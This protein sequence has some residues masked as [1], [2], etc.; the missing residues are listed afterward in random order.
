MIEKIEEMNPEDSSVS[1]PKRFGVIVADPPWSFNDKLKYSGTVKR[2]ADSH[3]PTLNLTEIKHLPI[4]EIAD[5]N[6]LLA[7]WVPS[8]FLVAGL[9]IMQAW[10]F[11]YKQLWVW[12]KTSKKNPLHLAFGMGRLA[13][14]CH[15]P[16][17]IGV[18]G[19]YTKSL[20]DHSQRNLFMH[21][22]TK[23]SQKPESIQAS[24]EKMFPDWQKLEI[25]ARRDRTGWTCIGN[26]APGTFGED[27]RDSIGNLL[28]YS[29]RGTRIKTG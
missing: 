19:N 10:G 22:S 4:S 20:Q 8:A 14:N 28:G 13:R 16:L 3:Y 17:L 5:D 29:L 7:L 9:D 15:E 26:E 21:P 24:L 2:S 18:R 11:E 27:V 6:A 1:S 23:H 12:G 25:F